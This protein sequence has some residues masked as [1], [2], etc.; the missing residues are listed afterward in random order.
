MEIRYY[1][2][3][4]PAVNFED[5]EREFSQLAHDKTSPWHYKTVGDYNESFYNEAQAVYIALMMAHEIEH[6]GGSDDLLQDSVFHEDYVDEVFDMLGHHYV[7]DAQ[8]QIKS[9]C[10]PAQHGNPPEQHEWTVPLDGL[11]RPFQSFGSTDLEEDVDELSPN[12][13]SLVGGVDFAMNQDT[14]S[15]GLDYAMHNDGGGGSSGSNDSSSSPSHSSYEETSGSE[16]DPGNYGWDDELPD[17]LFRTTS[18]RHE[19]DGAKHCILSMRDRDY[20]IEQLAWVW[21]VN[22]NDIVDT[23]NVHPP[24]DFVAMEDSWPII[25]EMQDDRIDPVNQ[26]LVI[27]Q[28]KYHNNP[29]AEQGETVEVSVM[30]VSTTSSRSEILAEAEVL[31]YCETRTTSRC[32]VWH[33]QERWKEQDPPRVLRDGDLISIE[34]PPASD[35]ESASTWSVVQD[36]YDGGRT[37]PLA[38]DDPTAQRD[39]HEYTA[40]SRS[41][42]PAQ[43]EVGSDISLESE[44]IE[45]TVIAAQPEQDHQ[46]QVELVLYGLMHEAVGEKRRRVRHLGPTT[47]NDAARSLWPE[48]KD[49]RLDIFVISPQPTNTKC[50]EIHIIAEFTDPFDL[51]HPGLSPVFEELHLT[52][53][54]GQDEMIRQP[55]YHHKEGGWESLMH[56]FGPWCISQASTYRC[57]VWISGQPM[58]ASHFSRLCPGDLVCIRI[59]HMRNMLPDLILDA[60]INIEAFSW[61]VLENSA[62]KRLDEGSLNI[63][64]IQDLYDQPRPQ[65]IPM[66]WYEQHLVSA[67]IA[68]ASSKIDR[69]TPFSVVFVPGA[70]DSGGD[71][72]CIVQPS[73][74]STTPCW[75][76]VIDDHES[77]HSFAMT[78]PASTTYH[79]IIEA[80]L[81]QLQPQHYKVVVLEVDGTRIHAG[82]TVWMKR[83]AKLSLRI[84]DREKEQSSAEETDDTT[85]LQLGVTK[86]S[87]G[88]D[89]GPHVSDRWCANGQLSSAFDEPKQ[90]MPL[91]IDDKISPSNQF[92]H[93]QCDVA[94]RAWQHLQDFTLPPF[95]DEKCLDEWHETTHQ[96]FQDM[97]HW[98]GDTPIGLRFYID[99]SSHFDKEQNIR[100]GAAATILIVDTLCGEQFGGMQ[101]RHVSLPATSPLSET[102]AL[103][104]AVLWAISFLNCSG[105]SVGLPIT[106]F[107]DATGPGFFAQGQWVPKAHKT[108]VDGCRNL[109]LWIQQ[110]SGAQCMWAHVKA[111]SGNP[112]KEAVDTLAKAICMGQI[113][114][115]HCADLWNEVA[116]G[117]QSWTW[118][119]LWFFEQVRWSTDEALQFCNTDLLMQLP[120]T[121]INHAQSLRICDFDKNCTK[122]DTGQDTEGSFTK[123][124]VASINVLS[125][126]AGTDDKIGAGN[127]VSA[128]M[129][130]ISRQCSEK[131]IDIVGLEETRH[132]ADHYFQIEEYHVLSG[133][134]TSRRTGGTQCWV[135]KNAFGLQIREEHL[136][137]RVAL[138]RVLVAELTHPQ[139]H[140]GIAVLHVPSSDDQEELQG[141]WQQV[142]L[143]LQPIRNVP[144]F[145]LM[146]ANSRVGTINSRCIGRHDAAVENCGGTCM[147]QWLE[148]NSL[149]IPST[150]SH[151][152]RGPSHTWFHSTGASARLDYVAIPLQF[153][154]HEV[155]TWIQ[156]DIDIQI[157]RADHA[158]ICLEIALWKPNRNKD[159]DGSARA[160]RS[161]QK[162]AEK[163]PR[164]WSMDVN[165]HADLLEFQLRTWST[166]L[167]T[168][169]T[170]RKAHLQESTW[171]LIKAKKWC[172]KNIQQM[173]KH[174]KTGVLREIFQQWRKLKSNPGHWGGYFQPWLK[175]TYFE[176]ARLRFLQNKFTKQVTSA[177]R[178]DDVDY[179]NNLAIRA[180]EADDSGGIKDIWREIKATLPKAKKRKQLNTKTVQ[181]DDRALQTH[182]DQLE[183]GEATTFYELAVGCLREQQLQRRVEVPSLELQ[184]FPSLLEVERLCAKVKTGKAPG[185]DEINPTII[186]KYPCEVGRE[187]F[188]VMFKA[189][190]GGEEPIAWK[191]G[192]LCPIFKGKG[193]K[194][195]ASSYRGVVLLSA[196]GKRW[197]ALLRARM[198]PHAI[199]NQPP[200]Q[201]GGFPGQQPGFASFIVRAYAARAK[202]HGLNE[203]C[204]F[205]DLRAAFHHLLRQLSLPMR[206]CRF[207]D[208]LV[209]A[210]R[211]DGHNVEELQQQSGNADRFGP[212]PLPGHLGKIVADLHQ[213]TWY[214]INGSHYTSRTHRGTRPGSPYAD[215]GFN[216]FMGQIMLEIQQALLEDSEL[217]IAAA[218]AQLPPTVVGWV[219]DIAIPM[220]ATTPMKLLEMI[221]RTCERVITVT[222][223]AGLMV[224]LDKGKTECVANFRGHGAPQM[225]KELFVDKGGKVALHPAE[226]QDDGSMELQVVGAYTHLGTCFGQDLNMKGEVL[227]RIGQAQSSYRLLQR[228]VFQNKRISKKTRFQ[229]L[230]S[231]VCTRLFYNM[232]VWGQLT[233]GLAKKLEHVMVGWF[234]QIAGDGFWSAE[235]TKDEMFM[236]IWE[237]PT[238][239]VR[240]AIAQLRFC[241]G[242]FYNARDTVW[243]FIKLEAD[244]SESSWFGILREAFVWFQTILPN[245]TPEGLDMQTIT[246]QQ[247]EVWFNGPQRPTKAHLRLL[248]RKHLLQER[249]VA[250][251]KEGYMMAHE[252]FRKHGL[253]YDGENGVSHGG[254]FQCEQCAATFARAQQLQAHRWSK[255]QGISLERR[256]VFGPTCKACG[257]QFWT[258]QRMQQHLRHSRRYPGGCLE[259]LFHYVEPTVEAIQFDIPDELRDIRRLPAYQA[260][261]PEV[262]DGPTIAERE[263]DQGLLRWRQEWHER[264]L[265]DQMDATLWNWAAPQISASFTQW[266]NEGGQRDLVEAWAEILEHFEHQHNVAQVMCQW[267]FIRWYR[268][269]MTEQM[270]DWMDPQLIQQA[271]N[272]GYDLITALP[273]LNLL[274]RRPIWS[275]NRH[276]L[277]PPSGCGAAAPRHAYTNRI[278]VAHEQQGDFLKEICSPDLRREQHRPPIPFL[279]GP[280]GERILVIIHMFSGRRRLFDFHYWIET[281]SPQLLKGW[282]TWVI[283]VDTAVHQIEGNMTGDNYKR[284]LRLAGGGTFIGS[285]SGPPCET[286]SPARHMPKPDNFPGRW[287]RPLRSMVRPWGLPALSQ[288]ELEQLRVGSKLYI[289]SALVEFEVVH[290]GGYSLLEHPADP[291]ESPK[292][293][294]WQTHF[295]QVYG[296]AMPGST[297]I[298][299]GQWKYGAHSVKP[300]I[301]RAMGGNRQTK[302]DLLEFQD[303]TLPKPKNVLAGLD[304]D[305]S[306]KTSAAKEYPW[307]LSKALAVTMLRGI[308]RGLSQRP[309]RDVS[310]SLLEGD[311]SWLAQYAR[312]SSCI[313]ANS[314]WL[315][316]YQR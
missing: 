120:S 2:T 203:A 131:T 95:L 73:R 241:I 21:G 78:L 224:N 162:R 280:D 79:Q 307:R 316:D 3:D 312:T 85:L 218:Q 151:V 248:L 277:P 80:A 285:L 201:F 56:G 104:Q 18:F 196:L 229:L 146:D 30:L 132:R 62:W 49:L 109:I 247:V 222:K 189:W 232:G 118:S 261:D 139:L 313:H 276:A 81:S 164:S 306:F 193:S 12:H 10:R 263:Y 55:V 138:D 70:A 27:R 227:R 219:D 105:C 119:W 182:F 82:S 101:G 48:W 4:E 256:Y 289:N 53:F 174:R 185:L 286:F 291:M 172:W 51:P 26:K 300:T 179:Y 223:K 209:R 198:L 24:P 279:C 274:D 176:E 215:L 207:P 35:G 157:S 243:E 184:D 44:P 197:H 181:P 266:G 273:L 72:V 126:F 122:Q 42:T 252:I 244:T 304:Q 214:T 100:V 170:R 121:G 77:R 295:H 60:F 117:D 16:F 108:F 46:P 231:L 302:Y 283:S 186:K 249:V 177:V 114:A 68:I 8:H 194:R 259:K 22:A 160:E 251:V 41:A 96:A 34:V 281:L 301:I 235:T 236:Q 88:V 246:P 297:S 123:L 39:L 210:L 134:A 103:L 156:D 1:D 288:G 61:S 28:I 155:H 65:N 76:T 221:Q 187:L 143:H 226:V 257:V 237:I 92:I 71:G 205:I 59:A 308:Q 124:R 148:R 74:W 67:V 161:R 32:L 238:L 217:E 93:I 142:D 63:C 37:V 254:N 305:G 83:G 152:H 262:F 141:W 284:I 113:Q 315:P 271:E 20:F 144:V 19:V 269:C 15:G 153:A 128:R 200:M 239:Q 115:P 17:G 135:A 191:G 255:H 38:A 69:A 213:S 57:D 145:V 173:W 225:R 192:I 47:F 245:K 140:I 94:F 275:P 240:I 130:A 298:Q 278:F 25:V 106:F 89:Y 154:D 188:E 183:A 175:W 260:V 110:R 102:W 111:H 13:T 296:K 149:W 228:S 125:L 112:W 45:R 171:E 147:H 137:T 299:I 314:H 212:L 87:G 14:G 158:P 195:E 202:M 206:D 292:V 107:G 36:L 287:P 178:Q 165:T 169:K 116:Q 7:S 43:D 258:S 52:Y 208:A 234:R 86:G 133:A 216:T 168:A 23:I 220:C 33:N 294:S 58:Q 303:H 253:T 163:N 84:A 250:E 290:N 31:N 136:R 54:D 166:E 267:L 242:A 129:E 9:G 311:F 98:E 204:L 5:A 29:Q 66:P 11:V 282:K 270:E 97:K 199:R 159:T 167:R 265:P 293:S 180:G 310:H 91:T 50:G 127:Y 150:F 309:L 75:I 190:A 272:D 99:G 64:W 90:K 233:P 40:N 264:G 6:H 211:Q 230:E 268:E